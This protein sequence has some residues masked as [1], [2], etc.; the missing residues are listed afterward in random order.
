MQLKKWHL[1]G[2]AKLTFKPLTS[3]IPCFG[4]VLVS[5]AEV[6]SNALHYMALQFINSVGVVIT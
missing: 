3:T 6:V 4:A 2:I 1:N 5:L